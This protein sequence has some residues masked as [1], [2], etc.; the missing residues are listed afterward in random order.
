MATATRTFCFSAVTLAGKRTLGFRAAV[1]RGQL[2]EF[3]QRD[4]LVLTNAWPVP[5]AAGLAG[6]ESSRIPLKDEAV[7]NRQLELLLERGVPLVEALEVAADVVTKKSAG[8]IVR[9]RE[10]VSAGAAFAE[11]CRKVG[12]FDDVAIGVY[13]A[14]ERSGDLGPAAGRLAETAERRLR[15]RG[16]LITTAIYPITVAVISIT[17]LF[18]ML[19]F[20]VPQL[21]ESVREVGDQ[22]SIPAFSE[23]VFSVGEF[24][25]AR[26]PAVLMFIIAIIAAAVLFRR[27]IAAGL[28]VVG[29]RIGPVRDLLR[30]TDLARF[31]SVLAAMSSSGVPLADALGSASATISDPKLRTQLDE[32][33]KNLMEGGLLRV[34]ID[35]V[36][37]LPAATRKLLVAAER[38]GDLDQAFE[39]LAQ[40]TSEDVQ[41]RSDRLSALMEPAIILVMFVVLA[42]LIVS[43]ALPM[44][45]MRTGG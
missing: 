19:V 32:L 3:L 24:L 18:G 16:K 13:R 11:A 8:R 33:R 6:D 36:S 23:F 9:L 28:G 31:F 1:D 27:S 30:V 22:T 21:A 38:S 37:E 20:I 17:L 15:M 41:T 39:S 43:I 44:I 12:G 34:L 25:N 4:G 26:L 10:Q 29:R 45:N 2:A 42:P 5:L 35:R 14:A 40:R 7:L